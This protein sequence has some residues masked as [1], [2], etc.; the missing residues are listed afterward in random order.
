MLLGSECTFVHVFGV[1]LYIHF[2]YYASN[3]INDYTPE[4]VAN[5]KRKKKSK[6]CWNKKSEQATESQEQNEIGARAEQPNVLASRRASKRTVEIKSKK[7]KK[8]KK[9][10]KKENK[11]SMCS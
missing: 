3:E 4:I 8:K 10:H 5:E 7:K 9:E 2:L 1:C 6:H 11:N